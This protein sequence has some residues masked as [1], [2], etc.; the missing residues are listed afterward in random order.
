MEKITHINSADVN[1]IG[2][3]LLLE[4]GDLLTNTHHLIDI[5]AAVPKWKAMH[6]RAVILLFA[7]KVCGF[8]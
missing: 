7:G 8:Q 2:S 6:W 4:D 3:K 1:H 5:R